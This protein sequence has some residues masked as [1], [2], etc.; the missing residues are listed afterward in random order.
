[1]SKLLSGDLH[2]THGVNLP[3]QGSTPAT[4][5][6][7]RWK[8][9]FTSTGKLYLDDGGLVYTVFNDRA[10]LYPTADG[11]YYVG[12]RALRMAGVTA[13]QGEFTYDDSV[14]NA[15]TNVLTLGHN[16]SGTPAASFGT[17]LIFEGETTTTTD[18]SMARI[19]S[20]WTTATHASRAARGILSAYD[21]AERD[22][23]MWEA[24]G[25]APMLAFYGVSPVVR[26][27]AITQTYSTSTRTLA[28]Y[29]PDSESG[30]YTGIDNAQGGTP[31][32]QLTDLNALRVA[33]EN[34]RAFVEN[35]VQVMNA[36]IDDF[37]LN[38]LEQ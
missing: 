18:T 35:S 13:Y 3:E 9:Y 26:A 11:F 20:V 23:F 24:S 37:Q 22:C 32:A 19:R 34:L 36:V 27:S 8:D 2:N 10:H 28:A 7:G 33:Y 12:S 5:A 15:V 1:M 4:P 25:S 29:T 30:A 16:S 31:Y 14:T 17:G 21:T 38:G 6:T